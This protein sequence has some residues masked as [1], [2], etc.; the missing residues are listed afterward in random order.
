MTT[1]LIKGKKALLLAEGCKLNKIKKDAE[2][3]LKEIK[4]EIDFK[5]D[6]TYKNEAG[7]ELVVSESEKFSDIQ[8]KKVL[9]YLKKMKMMSR[10]PEVIKVQITPLKKIIP[11]STYAKWRTKLDPIIKFSWKS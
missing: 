6:G 10:F 9:V 11:E 8:P 1:K 7:D 4:I 2:K 5:K 3:R